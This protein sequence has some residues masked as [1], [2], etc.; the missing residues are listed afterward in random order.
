[1]TKLSLIDLNKETDPHT[2][3]FCLPHAGA[4]AD[5]FRSWSTRLTAG[6]RL[7]SVNYPGRRSSTG[8]ERMGIHQLGEEV[9]HLIDGL[10]QARLVIFGH[11]MGALVGYEAL[12]RSSRSMDVTMIASGCPAPQ[13]RVTQPRPKDPQARLR[14]MLRQ[15]GTPPEILADKNFA[16]LIAGLLRDDLDAC[17]EYANPSGQVS[18]RLLALCALDDPVVAVDTVAPWNVCA[19]EFLG[20]KYFAGGHMFPFAHADQVVNLCLSV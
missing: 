14:K 9:A 16:A 10:P 2:V 8:V 7:V 1:M 3:L 20:L 13:V 15:G 11:S 5:V 17:D 4:N 18:A 6:V 12:A 19:A